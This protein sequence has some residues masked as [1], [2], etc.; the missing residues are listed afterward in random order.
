MY[1]VCWQPG[2]SGAQQVTSHLST[3]PAVRWKQE[4]PPRLVFSLFPVF[5]VFVLPCGVGTLCVIVLCR[6][7]TAGVGQTPRSLPALPTHTRRCVDFHLNLSRMCVIIRSSE[8]KK[9]D[10]GFARCVPS[11]SSLSL[12]AFCKG[13][14]EHL[15][16]AGC[17]SV[18]PGTCPSCRHDDDRCPLSLD[19]ND[20]TAP[21]KG[22]SAFL[23]FDLY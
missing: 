20:Y 11:D 12:S 18:I 21:P 13:G 7:R 22:E 2:I 14:R 9:L 23:C 16:S 17:H 15:L 6:V 1:W 4:D 3:P 5:P 10:C 19:S 8:I